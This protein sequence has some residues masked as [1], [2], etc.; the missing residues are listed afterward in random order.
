MR[1]TDEARHQ[2]YLALGVSSM[3]DRVAAGQVLE[4]AAPHLLGDDSTSDGFHTFGELYEHRMLLTAALFTQWAKTYN[5]YAVHKSWQHSDGEPCFGGD[6]FIVM[7][8]L[9]TGQISYHYP[10]AGWDL[11]QIPERSAALPYDDHTASD[12]TVR[13][14]AFLRPTD[15]PS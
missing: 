15:E 10:A 9:P 1:I 2:A 7:A 12:V 11:F 8:Q 13:L 4:A 5:A 14:W 3:D 6:W